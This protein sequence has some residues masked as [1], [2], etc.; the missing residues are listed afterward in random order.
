MTLNVLYL[1]H[2]LSDP[3]IRRRVMMLKAGGATVSVAGFLRDENRLADDPQVPVVVLGQTADGRLGQRLA[4]VFKAR[5]SLA[6]LLSGLRKPDVII[7]RNLEMLALA[8][9]ASARLGGGIPIVYECLDIHRLLLDPGAKGR[10]MRAAEGYFGRSASLLA[11]S[12]PAF[13]QHYFRPLSKLNLPV[14]LLENKVLELEP[15]AITA[16]P[17]PRP[18]APG[19]PWRIGW[20]GA[21]RCR[22][23]FD[24][25]SAFAAAMRGRV[26]IVI[27]GRISPKE[28]PDFD[29]MIAGAPHVTFHGTYRNPEDLARIYDEV[30]FVWAVDFF[31]EGLNSQWLLPNRLYEGALNGAV[32]I[33]I[34]STET[35]RFLGSRH[36]GLLLQ[37]AD[38]QALETR[39]KDLQP[40][41][42]HALSDALAAIERTQWA[43]G[44]AECRALVGQLAALAPQAPAAAGFTVPS[45]LQSES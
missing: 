12:S 36:L 29:R 3:A 35:G 14:L 16:R 17:T 1:A 11:T 21:I 30:Q 7:A 15:T 20:F 8:G 2:D 39:F 37:S 19:E 5:M 26:E 22:K 45:P 6:R 34:A 33:A 31:E 24:I 32:P 28:F 41:D 23:S 38:A 13:V 42:Y 18:P 25:L 9:S 40:A 4:A 43:A 10:L 27:R 44:P